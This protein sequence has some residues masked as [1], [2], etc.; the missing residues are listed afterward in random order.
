MS[1]FAQ[2]SKSWT[3]PRAT[4]LRVGAANDASEREADRIA[5]AVVSGGAVSWTGVR[6]G[7][8]GA[9]RKCAACED[10]EG[11]L[12]RKEAGGASAEGGW[13]APS[14][15]GEVLQS[16]GRPLESGVRGFMEQRFGHEFG[17]VRVHDDARAAESARAVGASA[18]TVGRDVVFGAGKYEPQSAEGRRLMAHELTH[19]IQQGAIS[20]TF[21]VAEPHTFGSMIQRTPAPILQ[22]AVDCSINHLDTE[23]G[24]AAARCAKIQN[25][26]CQKKYPKPEDIK[27]L[28]DNAISGANAQS[29]SS[30]SAAANLLHFLGGGDGERVMPVD[31]FKNHSATRD[32]LENEHRDKFIEG[33]KRRLASGELKPGGGQI[34]MAWTGTAN[35]FNLLKRDDLGLAV[36]GY[37]LC[38]KVK[39]SAVDRGGGSIEIRFDE[40]IVQAFDCYN[41]D[42]GKGVG[43]PGADDNDLCCLENAGRAMHYR[44][45]TDPWNNDDAVAI[46]SATLSGTPSSGGGGD[47]GGGGVKGGGSNDDRRSSNANNEGAMGDFGP[48]VVDSDSGLGSMSD[49]TNTGVT[50][51]DS[52][53]DTELG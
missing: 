12:Q 17:D 25:S 20:A 31:I 40:W 33:A 38:S 46:A 41:W 32:K 29:S 28:H 26:Y 30:P 15:V 45:R 49:G 44:I 24:G 13:E 4:G 50:M 1:M 6:A 14:I 35:A 18:Y 21:G 19:T 53:M 2:V 51:D 16:P 5:D 9:Q 36:G 22:R 23:C 8:A 39:V 52:V 43:I 47:G 11:T 37:T 48:T 34:E 27:K 10:E 42:P 7:G 3:P